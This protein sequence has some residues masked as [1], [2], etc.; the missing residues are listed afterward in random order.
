[1]STVTTI[2]PD[3]PAR[4][5]WENGV[6]QLRD[7]LRGPVLEPGDD[8]YDEARAIWN[9]MIDRRPTLIA[10]CETTGDVS[11]AVVFARRHGV[12]LSVRGCGHNIAG[13]AVCDGGLMIS[14]ARMS[15]VTVDP[16]SRRVRV[17]PGA[18]W[19]DVD[20]ATEPH[21]LVVHGGVVSTTGVAGFTVG[22]GFG[23]L[24]RKWGYSSDS[25]IS[26]T[27]VT[28][29]GQ[30]W[31][32]NL[33]AEPELFWGIR[34]GGGNFGIVTEFEF[35][36]QQLGPQVAAGLVLWPMDQAPAIIELFR[37]VTASAP[38]E[39]MHVLVMRVAPAAP[40]LPEAVHGKPVVGI[41]ACY[42]GSV[43]VGLEH[44]QPIRTFGEPLAE[45][46]TSKPFREHQSF[47]DSGQPYGRRYY[48]KSVYLP[49][50]TGGVTDALLQ[51]ATSFSSAFSSV[52][53]LHLGGNATAG[54]GD[55]AVS[56]RK[57]QYLVNYQASWED[58][59]Q[60]EEHIAW[61]RDNYASMWPHASG[62]YVNFMTEDEVRDP[63][64]QAYDPE[65]LAKLAI[66]KR[67]YDPEN[68]FCLN[69][70]VLP[71]AE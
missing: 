35:E 14:L 46:I 23:W 9:A 13:T 4:A 53:L 60:D 44:L 22:G 15:E 42:A 18:S 32:A 28:A 62:Q 11:N 50:F 37:R 58:P 17:G 3:T 45:T 26:A 52:L 24:T 49:E 65:T 10:L 19:G 68:R 66:V 54:D 8:G 25:L 55:S 64:R 12:P 67:K 6:S 63:A 56:N 1:M 69:K 40:F 36:A 57:A 21:G 29:D 48:W 47:L 7:Q 51:R 38:F 31:Q 27:V 59:T 71:S 70:N 39:L 30:I 20:R 61:A 5:V 2:K 43:E 34:G 33:D 41:A 16:D